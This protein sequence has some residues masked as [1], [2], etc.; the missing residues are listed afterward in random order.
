MN[1]IPDKPAQVLGGI[2]SQTEFMS[3]RQGS[4]GI[5]ITA[6]TR[7]KTRCKTGRGRWCA[8]RAP[9]GAIGM[10]VA[11]IPATAGQQMKPVFRPGG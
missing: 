3:A 9:S 4:S 7:A 5:P 6:K 10:L 8:R 1:L 11:T 2:D